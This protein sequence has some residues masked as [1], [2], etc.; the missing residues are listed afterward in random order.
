ML[1]SI[2]SGGASL[3]GTAIQGNY[4]AREASKNREFQER[5]SSTSHQREV[6]DLKAAGLNPI[7]SANA[8]ASS[9][10]GSAASISAP[11]LAGAINS[12]RGVSQQGQLIK[13]QIEQAKSSS[14][15]NLANARQAAANTILTGQSAR[16]AAVEADAAEFLG[17]DLRGGA[18]AVHTASG[19][20]QSG[21]HLWNSIKAG[22]KSIAKHGRAWLSTK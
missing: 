21:G 16:R 5:M 3:L 2:I 1:D 6:A 11:D 19:V 7:L 13:A 22:V 14:A 12:A 9:P 18:S 15:L 20:A 4:N 10:A 17:G 8:G